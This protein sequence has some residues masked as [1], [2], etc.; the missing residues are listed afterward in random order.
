[1]AA[2]A[3]LAGSL[4]AHAA[5]KHKPTSSQYRLDIL[6]FND[7]DPYR[8]RGASAEAVLAQRGAVVYRLKTANWM[9]KDQRGE[10]LKA[11]DVTARYPNRSPAELI[12]VYQ[13]D[14]DG[15]RVN[16]M[17]LVPDGDAIGDGKRYAPTILKRDQ[18]GYHPVWEASNLRGERFTVVD[19]RDLDGNGTPEILLMG[20]AGRRGYYQFQ[21]LVGRSGESFA[22]LPVRHVDSVHYVDLDVSGHV[23]IVL[24]ERVG[25]R[26]PASQWTYVDH[27]Y[28][29]DG[30]QFVSAEPLFPRYHD[31]ETLPTLLGDLI[32][33]YRAKKAILVE[34]VDAIKR[35][36]AAA[37]ARRSPPKKFRRGVVNA[38]AA[39]QKDQ[40]TIARR[41]L[42]DLDRV[43]P[44]DTQVLLGLAR[45]HAVGG[46]ASGP[47]G[48]QGT[49]PWDHVLDYAI[50]ALTVDPATREAWWWLGVAFTQLHER[51]SA[52]ASF[53][54]A[55]RLCGPEDE[56]TA[57]LR[58]RRGEPG[59]E[60][61][62][63][64]AIDQ[65]LAELP[66]H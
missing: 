22:S 12:A 49:S 25:R 36:R 33:N 47:T 11:G 24:R 7:G 54:H 40:L 46:G 15:D 61:A 21:E 30:R 31:E 65:A 8:L 56:G 34:K 35:V 55:V 4:G 10:H 66:G 52:V 41:R 27:L 5:P 16:E 13:L 62:L 50:R 3:T 9:D 14:L 2:A 39:L 57:F 28:Q 63:Q 60:A 17:L 1:L 19:I 37:L 32:D 45:I 23:E 64:Q 6:G 59:M 38:L 44:Y 18:F 29:W 51:S 43:Y 42:E 53:F 20:E 58:A 26:G 48:P